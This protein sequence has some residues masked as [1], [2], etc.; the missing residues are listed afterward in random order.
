MFGLRAGL[1]SEETA[2]LTL[3][4][5]STTASSVGASAMGGTLREQWV[6]GGVKRENGKAFLV[7]V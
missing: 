4:S 2:I 3:L 5:K 1:I 6:F 7:L